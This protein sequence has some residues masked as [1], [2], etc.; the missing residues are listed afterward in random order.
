MNEL[1]VCKRISNKTNRPYYVMGVDLGYRFLPLTFDVNV[2]AEACGVGV[3]EVYA[4]IVEEV[5]LGQIDYAK[6]FEK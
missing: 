4:D 3:G 2:I 5:V 1:K 6:A